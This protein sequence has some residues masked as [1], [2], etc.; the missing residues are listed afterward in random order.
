MAIRGILRI[1]ALVKLMFNPPHRFRVRLGG[2]FGA[3]LRFVRLVVRALSSSDSA[4]D[5][6]SSS[7]SSSSSGDSDTVDWALLFLEALA[8]D[9]V[10]FVLLAVTLLARVVFAFFGVGVASAGVS[11]F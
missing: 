4:L 3:R 1:N 7:S 6:S 8:P 11:A 2:C 5:S 10:P 9:F